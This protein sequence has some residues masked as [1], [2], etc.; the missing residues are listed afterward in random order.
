MTELARVTHAD[1]GSGTANAIRFR[2]DRGEDARSGGRPI[3]S[4]PFVGALNR[5]GI[6]A[7]SVRF[8]HPAL[9]HARVSRMRTPISR[10]T[11]VQTDPVPGTVPSNG[12]S[13]DPGPPFAPAGPLTLAELE[14]AHILA[15]LQRL[16]GNR[17][18]AAEVLGI[19]PRTLHRRMFEYGLLA[20]DG[21]D[22]RIESDAPRPGAVPE[23]Q[24]VGRDP[25]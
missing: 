8:P 15:V 20:N 7:G 17:T 4:T 23:G 18:R 21:I 16:C 11:P 5:I 9:E 3:R 22:P 13:P 2:R 12:S 1:A 24:E 10:S 19:P 14:R 6:A 25:S